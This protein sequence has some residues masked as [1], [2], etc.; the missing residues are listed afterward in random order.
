MCQD[1]QNDPDSLDPEAMS[2]AIAE[3]RYLEARSEQL[4]RLIALSTAAESG[5]DVDF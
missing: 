1:L 4:Q 5:A 3:L 2:S